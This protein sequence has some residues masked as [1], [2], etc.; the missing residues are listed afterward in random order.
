MSAAGSILGNPEIF[1]KKTLLL[2]ENASRA[3]DC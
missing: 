2:V 3:M 1:I